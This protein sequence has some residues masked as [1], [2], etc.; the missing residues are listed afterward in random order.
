MSP[1]IPKSLWFVTLFI[2]ILLGS[3]PGVA[4]GLGTWPGIAA[5]QER[6]MV[7]SALF[8]WFIWPSGI[9]QILLL[10]TGRF[11]YGSLAAWL[12]W[13]LSLGYPL[14][15]LGYSVCAYWTI[16]YTGMVRKALM[17]TIVAAFISALVS[18]PTAIITSG[19]GLPDY[20]PSLLW[21]VVVLINLL[22]SAVLG[23]LIGARQARKRGFNLS[24]I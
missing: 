13:I 3:W 20:L 4:L 21:H 17:V 18:I 1:R 2:A 23:W 10:I 14:T 16:C 24:D 6:W 19:F 11:D 8:G 5:G 7:M 12:T 9:L 15:M 22:I